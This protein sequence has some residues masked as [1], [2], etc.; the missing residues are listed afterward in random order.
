MLKIAEKFHMKTRVIKAFWHEFLRANRTWLQYLE[1]QERF[2]RAASTLL[3]FLATVKYE[4]L[5]M[6]PFFRVHD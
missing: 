1:I 3:G 4:Y 6:I 5:S 2:L